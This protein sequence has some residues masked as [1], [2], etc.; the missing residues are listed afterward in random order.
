MNSR[1]KVAAGVDVAG[2]NAVDSGF[3]FFSLSTTLSLENCLLA[4]GLVSHG[5]Q[6]VAAGPN[7]TSILKTGRRV[8]EVALAPSVSFCKESKNFP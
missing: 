3:F 6:R 5:C 7:I 1:A 4:S 2:C 8:E